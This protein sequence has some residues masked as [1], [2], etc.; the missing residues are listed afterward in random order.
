MEAQVKPGHD[1]SK[2]VIRMNRQNV[3]V[4]QRGPALI[5]WPG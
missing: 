1:E 5:E 3:R 2:A 4:T